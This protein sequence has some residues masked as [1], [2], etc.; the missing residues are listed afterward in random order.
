MACLDKSRMHLVTWQAWARSFSPYSVGVT[1]GM[2]CGRA[3]SWGFSFSFFSVV[4]G[5][6]CFRSHLL[7]VRVQGYFN[8]H[9]V[10]LGCCNCPLRHALPSGSGAA[11]CVHPR[12]RDPLPSVPLNFFKRL[13]SQATASC[14]Q[15]W[16]VFCR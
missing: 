5:D 6:L 8:I 16:L 12:F 7:L 9:N 10:L 14:S 3:I 13:P 2:L 11:G 15:A 1:P 4:F